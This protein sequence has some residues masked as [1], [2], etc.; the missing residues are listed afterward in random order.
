MNYGNGLTFQRT[1]PPGGSQL[2]GLN[3]SPDMQAVA[4]AVTDRENRVRF[5]LE[6]GEM[7]WLP[8]A[9]GLGTT[10]AAGT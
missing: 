7:F 4:N 1:Y 3:G 8:V 6:H 5:L 10:P 2:H 9:L